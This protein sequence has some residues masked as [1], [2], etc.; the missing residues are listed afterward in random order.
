[1]IP[2]TNNKNRP[3]SILAVEDDEVDFTLLMKKLEKISYYDIQL[4]HISFYDEAKTSILRNTHDVYFIDYTL[5]QKSGL[6]L[7]EEV[8]SYG[9][10]GPFIML[11]GID[12]PDLYQR[13]SQTGV[14]D[15]LLK[16]DL[17]DSQLLR[18][19]LY[20]LERKKVEDQLNE[21]RIFSDTILKEAPYMV[22][23]IDSS[24]II[25][26]INPRVEKVT[27]YDSDELIGQ[28]WRNLIQGMDISNDQT[29]FDNENKMS[30]TNTMIC[31]GGQKKTV[32]WTI[33]HNT[34]RNGLV[35]M[36]GKDITEELAMQERRRQDEKMKALGHLAGGVA[37]EINNLLQPILM[38]AE[39]IIHDNDMAQAKGAA[40]D[41]VDITNTATT[42]VENVIMLAQHDTQPMEQL[43][44]LDGF[45][46]AI[47]VCKEQLPDSIEIT[48]KNEAIVEDV[49]CL[50]RLKN[51]ERVLANL[52]HNASDAMRQ[53]GIIE[54]CLDVVKINQHDFV[55]VKIIDSGT[56]IPEADMDNIF[57]PFFT[58]KE[59]GQGTGLGLTMA[60]NLVNNWGG[61]ITVQNARETGAEFTFT[62]PVYA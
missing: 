27:Q 55:E 57:N 36:M 20:T 43:S 54:V 48:V 8:T 14:Y 3:L 31:K 16:K 45:R 58:S 17:N 9:H 26:A 38:R 22:I 11:T 12:R 40:E 30:F 34:W 6:E 41:I 5:G 59:V 2:E 21:E 18:T 23:T 44:F 1:M 7:V 10:K 24:S 56:G 28:S 47:D 53:K 4:D 62:I 50:F 42:L 15:Y 60:Y 19:L 32:Q 29:A 39:D 13:S 35:S 33:L 25:H 52:C 46:N 37:H 49:F 51:L 61:K